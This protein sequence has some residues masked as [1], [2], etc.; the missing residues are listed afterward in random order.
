MILTVLRGG[1]MTKNRGVL[2]CLMAI[3]LTNAIGGVGLFGCNTAVKERGSTVLTLEGNVRR[4][5]AF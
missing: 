4:V 5:V 2:F 3:I 1:A